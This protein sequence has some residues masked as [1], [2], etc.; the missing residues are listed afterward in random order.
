MRPYSRAKSQSLL[1][2]QRWYARHRR[3]WFFAVF[4]VYCFGLALFSAASVLKFALLE[5]KPTLT[6]WMSDQ[7]GSVLIFVATLSLL[8]F[9][10]F[11]PDLW[12]K[13]RLRL[14]PK[15]LHPSTEDEQA[16]LHKYYRQLA[17]KENPDE[18]L[19]R[20]MD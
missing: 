7:G 14:S 8:L 16:H 11:R 3:V 1:E 4:A 10:Y 12:F 15:K 9:I 13:I 20:L 5:E 6:Q 2:S 18:S 17:G 19:V